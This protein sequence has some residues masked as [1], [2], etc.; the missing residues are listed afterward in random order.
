MSNEVM[1]VF[2]YLSINLTSLHASTGRVVAYILARSCMLHGLRLSSAQRSICHDIRHALLCTLL[3]V[4]SLAR[5]F[6]PPP[7]RENVRSRWTTE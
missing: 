6:N 2:V 7:V 1:A 3:V 5:G 4:S